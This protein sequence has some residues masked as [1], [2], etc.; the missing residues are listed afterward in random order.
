MQFLVFYM[1][2][3]CI[4]ANNYIKQRNILNWIC[5][6]DK[7]SVLFSKLWV[8]LGVDKVVINNW[9]NISRIKLKKYNMK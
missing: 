7:A 5:Y 6:M 4:F 3:F 8:E 2:L 1:F 9:T